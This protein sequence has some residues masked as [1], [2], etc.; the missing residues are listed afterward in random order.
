MKSLI[1]N[2]IKIY[3]VFIS[4]NLVFLTGGHGCKFRPTCAEYTI[5][6]VE[7]DGVVVGLRKGLV[8]FMK[9]R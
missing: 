2:L 6:T 7:E 5:R 8:R 4:P 9:C 3:K 1:I